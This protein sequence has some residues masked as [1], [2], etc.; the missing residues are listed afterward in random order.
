MTGTSS[1]LQPLAVAAV[2]AIGVGIV[3]GVLTDVGPW[4]RALKV[5]AWKPPDWA[6]GPVWTTIFI[7]CTIAIALAWRDGDAEQRRLLIVLFVVNAVLNILWSALFF[8]LR[9]PDLALY[10]VVFL[11]LSIAAL[12]IKLWPMNTT[13]SLL[14]LPY[15]VWVSTASALNL[16]IVRLNGL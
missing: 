6:F 2:L 1:L 10:E 11:W 7:C 3:G 13:A 14:L 12:M 16:A 4:Y 8:T 5:P 9:R 15:I